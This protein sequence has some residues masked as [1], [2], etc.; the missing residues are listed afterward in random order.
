MNLELDG[1]RALVTGGNSGIGKAM[2]L[3]F[4]DAAAHVA[5]NYVTR[6]EEAE[7]VAEAVRRKGLVGR[8]C[9]C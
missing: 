4:A 5:I 6:P 2:A 3:A 7:R 8:I 9:A 1:K